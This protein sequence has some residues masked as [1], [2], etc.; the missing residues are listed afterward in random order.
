MNADYSTFFW[1]KLR[2]GY[3]NL[4]QMNLTEVLHFVNIFW[5]KY[6]FKMMIF[7]VYKNQKNDNKANGKYSDCRR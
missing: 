1:K 7:A 5:G 3:Q 6:F 4:C 2:I